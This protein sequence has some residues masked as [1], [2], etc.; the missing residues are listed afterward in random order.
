MYEN[1]LNMMKKQGVEFEKGLTLDELEQIE[2]I[3]QI[4][5]PNS[6]KNFLM[7]ALPISN[8]FYNWRNIQNDNIRFIKKILN[9]PFSDVYNMAR[10]VYWCDNWGK[11]PEDEKIIEE[12]VRKRLKK[13]PILLPIYAHRYI[14]IILDENPPVISIHDVDVIYYGKDLED[15]FN[16]EFGKKIQDTI[17]FQ[18]VL[19]ISFWSDIM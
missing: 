8:G 7:T 5:F 11:D 4:K 12:E 19:P 13:A 2:K 10:E 18:K 1:I 9:K 6:L 14:P 15:Y 17:E 3:Y 16:I